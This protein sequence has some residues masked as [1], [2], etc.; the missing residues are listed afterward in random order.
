[1]TGVA[2]QSPSQYQISDESTIKP[3]NGVLLGVDRTLFFHRSDS[4]DSSPTLFHFSTPFYYLN[5]YSYQFF[6]LF[7]LEESLIDVLGVS[8]D[9]NFASIV[10]RNGLV[11][12][13][14][15]TQSGGPREIFSFVCCAELLCSFV[16]SFRLFLQFF[17]CRSFHWMS[18]PQ[19]LSSSPLQTSLLLLTSC[20]FAS[21]AASTSSFHASRGTQTLA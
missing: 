7:S 9:S 13:Y 14:H 17:T 3:S 19:E 11:T 4:P 6:F 10:L 21:P 2:F 15:L 20:R 12:F 18:R 1:M 16:H 8:D 5:R